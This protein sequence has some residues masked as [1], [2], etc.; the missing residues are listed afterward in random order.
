MA[1]YQHYC[2]VYVHIL[3]IDG[4]NC[5]LRLNRSVNQDRC[6]LRGTVV[7]NDNWKN[8][9]VRSTSLIKTDKSDTIPQVLG[10]KNE[11]FDLV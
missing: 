8:S 9:C 3:F 5:S 7:K 2:L 1:R 11:N 10:M 4:F 6:I